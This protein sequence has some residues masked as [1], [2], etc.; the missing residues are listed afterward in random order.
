MKPIGEKD[1]NKLKEIQESN[2]EVIEKEKR[3]SA[4]VKQIIKEEYE[5]ETD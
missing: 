5:N 4:K 1:F 2:E 3:I